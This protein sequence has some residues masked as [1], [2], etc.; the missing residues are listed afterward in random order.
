MNGYTK[1]A[2]LMGHHSE[3]AIFRRFGTLNARN[4]LYLQAELV[5]LELK[6]NRCAAADLASHDPD[7]AIYDRDWQTLSESGQLPDGNPE[8]WDTI[9]GIRK[10]LKEYSKLDLTYAAVDAD[11]YKD[12]ALVLQSLVSKH[13]SPN[14]QDLKF[15]QNWMK[16]PTMGYV[17]LLGADSDIWEKPDPAD[18]IAIQCRESQSFFSH[19]LGDFV[20]HWY[21]RCLGKR[22]RVST[23]SNAVDKAWAY[24]ALET[25]RRWYIRQHRALLSG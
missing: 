18:L 13:D 4:L 11:M 12:E 10:T 23:I 21:H 6:L 7:R 8:Q 14:P 1:L 9:L 17:Y 19:F 25:G 24:V 3:L 15:L 20:I 2:S 16:R 5:H 22:F